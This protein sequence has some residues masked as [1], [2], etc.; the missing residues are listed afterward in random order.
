MN[1][2]HYTTRSR[3]AIQKGHANAQS[4]GNPVFEPEHLLMALLNDAEGL[5]PRLLER[6]GVSVVDVRKAFAEATSRF[7]TAIPG[8]P[9]SGAPPGSSRTI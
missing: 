2:E 3:E 7:P 6:I 8:E 4:R 1:I 5:I 9:T